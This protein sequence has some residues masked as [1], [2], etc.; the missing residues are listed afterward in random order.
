MINVLIAEDDFRIA[1][2]HERFL[3][4]IPG[5][6]LAGKA[7]TGEETLRLLD[8]QSVDLLLLD[9]YMPDYLGT[10][11][12]QETRRKQ[13]ELD[14]IVITA[15]QEKQFLE[16]SLRKGVFNYLI[17]PVTLE[18]FTEV[19]N[20]YKQRQSLLKSKDVIDQDVVDEL[21][22]TQAG[23]Q[24]L[25]ESLPKGIDP[26]TLSKVVSIIEG[27]NQGW[28]AEE[29][30]NKIGA[31]RTTARRY[32]EYLVS[33]DKAEAEQEYGIVGRPERKYYSIDA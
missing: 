18:R 3:A 21:F 8:E 10:E 1:N 20:D 32:L 28:T 22:T 24:N 5:V 15:A 27:G 14:I 23:K 26:I 25:P 17:K 9:I 16:E 2:I 7:L 11:L 29:M 31:S 30:G 4:D 13:P 12:I 6:A 33:I 19:L